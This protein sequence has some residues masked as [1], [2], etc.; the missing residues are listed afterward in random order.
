MRSEGRCYSCSVLK[1]PLA[2]PVGLP[3]KCAY[4]ITDRLTLSA[5]PHRDWHRAADFYLCWQDKL[6]PSHQSLHL[7]EFGESLVFHVRFECRKLVFH[8]CVSPKISVQSKS[9][10]QTF[11]WGCHHESMKWIKFTYQKRPQLISWSMRCVT[12]LI[13]QIRQRS[14]TLW[15][16]RL[17]ADI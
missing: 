13:R 12:L 6:L 16:F 5:A 8:S 7:A 4:C 9:T 2:H 1:L 15:Q 11:H 3:E 10:W 17:A 14:T